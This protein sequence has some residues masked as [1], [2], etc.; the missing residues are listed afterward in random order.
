MKLEDLLGRHID[1]LEKLT[2]E[3]RIELCKPYWPVT[4]PDPAKYKASASNSAPSS[5]VKKKMNNLAQAQ[6]LYKQFEHMFD[7]P[8][9][10]T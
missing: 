1:E 3:Q 10:K 5:T 8:K 4:R 7:A 9:K 2:K 6:A